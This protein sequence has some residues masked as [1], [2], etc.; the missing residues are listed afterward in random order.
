MNS[1]ENWYCCVMDKYTMLRS[2]SQVKTVCRAARMM[3]LSRL[4]EVLPGRHP[5]D[6]HRAK[7]RAM[8]HPVN[9]RNTYDS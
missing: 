7:I 1:L 3:S 2:D 8:Q 4:A 9:V 5:C 6:W